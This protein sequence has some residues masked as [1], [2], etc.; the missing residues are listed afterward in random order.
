MTHMAYLKA[1][2][3]VQ[4]PDG[5]KPSEEVEVPYGEA[6]TINMLHK[7]RLLS[8]DTGLLRAFPGPRIRGRAVP[9]EKS[10]VLPDTQ[11]IIPLLTY[12]NQLIAVEM[13]K[14]NVMIR[15]FLT[16]ELQ[17]QLR[18]TYEKAQKRLTFDSLGRFSWLYMWGRVQGSQLLTEAYTA[19]EVAEICSLD[20]PLPKLIPL[21]T[22]G[23][24]LETMKSFEYLPDSWLDEILGETD[25][26]DPTL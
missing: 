18:I 9:V 1:G 12:A 5:T 15:E 26:D 6:P 10:L 4:E 11:Y 24:S 3:N 16:N 25:Y 14:D 17:P 19:S 7:Y 8:E 21:V 22:E 13:G 2:F 20:I 23:E